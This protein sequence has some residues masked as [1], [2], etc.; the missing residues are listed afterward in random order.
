MDGLKDAGLNSEVLTNEDGTD[1]LEVLTDEDGMDDPPRSLEPPPHPEES[2]KRIKAYPEHSRGPFIVFFRPIKKPL[3]VI[4]IG[5]DLAK[6]FSDV[7]EITKVRPN[8]L[9]VVV[10]SLKQA[11]AIVN[12]ELFTREYRVYIPAKDVEIDGVVTEEN[13][14][15]DDLLNQAVGCFKNPLIP[16]V[17]MLECKILHSASIVNGKKKYVPSNSFRVTFAGSALPDYILLDRVRLPVRLFVPRVMNCLNCK[18]LGH[19]ATYCC[20]KARCNKCGENHAE[21]ACNKDTEKCLYC[22][23]APHDLS[24]CPTYKQRGEKIKRSLKERSKRSFAEMLKRA[25]PPTP[26]NIYSF[27]PIDGDISDDAGEGCSYATQQRSRKRK[28]SNSPDLFRKGRK[29]SPTGLKNIPVTQNGSGVQKP[30]PV[31]P[32]FRFIPNQQYPPLPKVPKTPGKPI[33]RAEEK[34]QKGF[35][36]FSDIVD[37]ILQTFNISDPLKSLL[38]AFLPTVKTFLKQLTA[39]W[40]LLAVIVSFDD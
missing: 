28:N 11:N 2:N 23:E 40:P 21:T 9:R 6:Q 37:W 26:G 33:L 12:F 29:T 5:K 32:G 17:K 14:T 8:K 31:P 36:K 35:L 24:A 4:Q 27:L 38:L 1:D 19:T 34:T 22:G 16:K 13:L 15:A 30:K 10:K 7:T 39:Q 20:N 18:Q 3:N 25:Q